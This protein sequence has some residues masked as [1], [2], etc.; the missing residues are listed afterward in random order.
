MCWTNPGRQPTSVP[1]GARVVNYPSVKDEHETVAE[2]CL[3]RSIARF[4]DGELK[5]VAGGHAARE[6]ANPELAAELAQI[7]HT[8]NRGCIVG[9]PTMDPHGP[10]FGTWSKH[11][12]RFAPLLST[13]LPYYSAFISRP[14]SAPWIET[15]EFCDRLRRLWAGR[16]VVV[17]C[18]RKGSIYRAVSPDAG[19]ISHVECPTHRSYEQIN[20]LLKL[21]LRA[22]PEIVVLSAGP[23]ATCMA[24]RLARLDVHALDLGSAGKFLFRNL[25]PADLDRAFPESK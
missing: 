8:P 22:A 25:W 7:L 20:R 10:K 4:G 3:G 12:N 24:N 18:E 16:R 14:D 2:I 11:L 21:A 19:H 5:L 15:F 6:P 9:I 1:V 17:I 13:S 23:A